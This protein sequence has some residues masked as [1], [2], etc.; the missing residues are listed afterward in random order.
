MISKIIR[1]NLLTNLTIDR[2]E[3]LEKTKKVYDYK[4]YSS[5]E[6]T[7]VE[8]KAIRE[9]ISLL[10]EEYDRN[11][12]I[13][14]STDHLHDVVMKYISTDNV[15]I[16]TRKYNIRDVIKNNFNREKFK[17]YL[18]LLGESA[19]LKVAKETK[20]KYGDEQLK[21]ALKEA[22]ETGKIN[23]FTNDN[24]ARS[25]LGLILPR[26]L[27]KELVNENSKIK[28]SFFDKISI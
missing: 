22:G 18:M 21:E 4:D 23:I 7:T 13:I 11:P 16:F 5:K 2:L 10:V 28:D 9:I 14:N 19:M 17:N 1:D 25:E 8:R 3:E 26:D 15:G 6:I 24:G 27:V 20:N 12:E